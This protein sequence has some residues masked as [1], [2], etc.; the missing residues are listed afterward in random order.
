MET[1]SLK[2]DM[3]GFVTKFVLPEFQSPEGYMR[4]IVSNAD[5]HLS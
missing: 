2:G 5:P 3:E 1:K 4:Q